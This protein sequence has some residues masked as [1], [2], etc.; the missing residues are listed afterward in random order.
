MALCLQQGLGPGQCI[1]RTGVV[2]RQE[3]DCTL[4]RIQ[5]GLR[6]GHAGVPGLQLFPLVRSGGQLLQL[7]DLPEQ[8]I[9]VV[10]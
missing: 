1:Q 7:V 10:L 3:V 4:G 2:V 8:A 5:Q 9:P 6:M